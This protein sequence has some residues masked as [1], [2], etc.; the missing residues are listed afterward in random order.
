MKPEEIISD[1]EIEHV[2]AN[3]QFGEIPKR[4]VVNQALFKAACGYHNG[5]TARQIITE[6]GLVKSVSNNNSQLTDKG[7]KYLWAA[8]G[9]D[10]W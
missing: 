8:F 1:E 6:H 4:V 10:G 9:M 5:Y 2:H 7:R 3:A